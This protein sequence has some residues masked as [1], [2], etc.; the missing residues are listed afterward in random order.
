MSN[1]IYATMLLKKKE[2]LKTNA[3]FEDI[4]SNAVYETI[5]NNKYLYDKKIGA[6]AVFNL[7]D[8]LLEI[9][10]YREGVEK[11]NQFSNF[12]PHGLNFNMRQDE[13]RILLGQPDK[14]KEA[15]P[16]HP[17]L[18]YVWA[19]DRFLFS[20]YKLVVKYSKKN[21]IDIIA[22]GLIDDE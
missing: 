11:N 9:Q 17:L 4:F 21:I 14:S 12:I 5:L 20:G 7:S 15:V 10:L 13:V 18:G 3:L 6:N 2:V 16:K 8:E 1:F 22:I 19:W